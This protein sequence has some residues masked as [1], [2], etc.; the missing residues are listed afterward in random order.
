MIYKFIS[1]LLIFVMFGI[2]EARPR[3]KSKYKKTTKVF[4]KYNHTK[5]KKRKKSN[6]AQ[7]PANTNN[8]EIERKRL[9]VQLQT[10]T[11]KEKQADIYNQ[12]S[13]L[14]QN[15]YVYEDLTKA[16]FYLKKSVALSQ[17]K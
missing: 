4:S 7:T 15:S 12:I 8:P 1:A 14:Y 6:I 3:V 10:E 11:D 5:L 16:I 2:L 13:T 9:L 17:N